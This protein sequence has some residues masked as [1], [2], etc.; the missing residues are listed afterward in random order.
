MQIF[1]EAAQTLSFARVA[2]RLHLT[3]SAVSFQIKQ[4][5]I[6]VG[7]TL[8]ERLG[9]T[10]KL[11]QAGEA[12]LLY[13]RQVLRAL[14]DADQTLMALKGLDAGIPQAN[15][16]GRVP[17]VGKDCL[18]IERGLYQH[19]APSG[20]YF[21]TERY[22]AADLCLRL[23]GA[24]REN[25]YQPGVEL[26]FVQDERPSNRPAASLASAQESYDAWHFDRVWSARLASKTAAS[27]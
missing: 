26:H 27:N 18:M 15:V 24:G 9:K 20:E 21:L 14:L 23:Q 17:G 7:F 8:F 25:W 5:E 16:Q 6:V 13:A 3:P 10:V 11:T 4:I 2:E 19:I 1:S 22:E 12:L